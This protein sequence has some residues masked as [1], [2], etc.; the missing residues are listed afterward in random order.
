MVYQRDQSQFLTDLLLI[1]EQKLEWNLGSLGFLEFFG[2]RGVGIVLFY[3]YSQKWVRDI[4]ENKMPLVM[5]I[6]NL[7]K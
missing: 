4:I 6:C 7:S 5:S 3:L 1:F 2:G